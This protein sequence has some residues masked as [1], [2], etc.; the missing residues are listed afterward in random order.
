V[1]SSRK[2]RARDDPFFDGW[3]LKKR[4]LAKLAPK[5]ICGVK[6]PERTYHYASCP[7]LKFWNEQFLKFKEEYG[8]RPTLE[9]LVEG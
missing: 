2:V 7:W 1:N 3:R 4:Q 9:G 8:K 6:H 5:C